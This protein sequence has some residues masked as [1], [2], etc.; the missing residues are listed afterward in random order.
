VIG[1]RLLKEHFGARRAAGTVLIVAGVMALR[2]AQ[3]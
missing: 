1:T 3:A 2:L